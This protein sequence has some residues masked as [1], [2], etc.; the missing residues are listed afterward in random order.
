[1][2]KRTL[3]F[4]NPAYLS[5][6][7]R[8]LVVNFPS[9]EIDRRQTIPVEDIGIVILDNRQIT[10]T[11]AV[12]EALLQNNAAVIVCD[13]SHMPVGLNLPL[14]GNTLQSERF[15]VQLKASLPLKKQLWQQTV[16]CKIRNQAAVLRKLHN[17]E[18]G[19]ITAWAAKVKSGDPD[20]FEARAAAYYWKNMFPDIDDFNRDRYGIYPNSLLNYAY[21]ILRAMV[22]RA[23]VSAGML[24]TLGI[25]HHN[26]YNAYCL[27]DDIMEPYRPIADMLV[28]EIVK[29]NSEIIDFE[30]TPAIKRRLLTIPVIDTK[31]N[32]NTS[33]MINAVTTTAASLYKCFAKE[34]RK[35]IYPEI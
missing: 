5:Y 35:I 22:A 16:Q 30:I 24:P 14:D 3:C 12:F 11:Q 19:N 25:H 15:A 33:P 8:Q 9:N 23:L 1:M 13:N 7:N 17:T 20:N 32:G 29:E 2:I 34:T 26:R 10:I 27:A 28:A 18:T 4:S 21:A 31:I 6:A